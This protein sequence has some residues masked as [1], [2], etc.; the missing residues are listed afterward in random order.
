MSRKR[1]S[2][3]E[4]LIDIA[5]YLPWWVSFLIAIVTYIFL[6]N[7]VIADI[8]PIQTGIVSDLGR[9]ASDNI[10]KNIAT[11][12]QYIFPTGFFIGSVISFFKHN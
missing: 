10:Y 7:L 4:D 8:Q 1:Q 3:F 9:F 11:F 6:H 2:A 12:G 5:S